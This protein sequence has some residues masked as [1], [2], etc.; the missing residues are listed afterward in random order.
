MSILMNGLWLHDRQLSLRP[1]IPKPEPTPGEALVRVL[2]AGV[3]NT[4]LELTRG[5]YPYSGV[6]G[7]E[8]VGVVEA[9]YTPWL[10]QRVVGEINASCGK[11]EFCQKG[12]KTHCLDRTVLGIVNRNG[13]FAEYLSL[14]IQNL[15]QV[16]ETISTDAATFTEPLAAALQ[17]LEQVKITP[18]H[19]VLIVGDGKLGLLVAQA[20]A[21]TDCEVLAIGRH[22]SKLQ[23]L[24]DCG[25]QTG[26]ASEIQAGSFDVAVECT[27][28]PEGFAI[29]LGALKARGTLVLKSTYAGKLSL[30][31]AK[32]VVDEIQLVGSRCG[33]FAPALELLA[34]G[35]ISVLPM[36]QARFEL[37]EGLAAMGRA[38]QKGTLKVLIDMG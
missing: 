29:A 33:A 12:I 37:Q 11:C 32:I 6:L 26:F 36:V 30:D 34:S 20:I 13:A 14:P 23:I 5:Y 3:C 16:P 8:F 7:H 18:N 17:I 1:D 38:A 10:K 4:D 19:R 9:G 15:Y 31:A 28:N 21:T 25:I 24:K 35:K 2:R 27:G 22:E